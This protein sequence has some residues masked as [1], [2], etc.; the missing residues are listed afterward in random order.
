MVAQEKGDWT[1]IR[2]LAAQ[3]NIP[4]DQIANARWE[5]MQW[6]RQISSEE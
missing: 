1:E 2:Q 4:E 6:A 3:T 5:A